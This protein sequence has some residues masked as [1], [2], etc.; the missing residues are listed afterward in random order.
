MNLT[1]YR[2]QG[3][4]TREFL[5]AIEAIYLSSTQPELWPV[6]LQK[7]ADCFGDVG[8]ALLLQRDDGS[9]IP[10]CSTGLA[11]VQQDY[12]ENGWN[13][14]DIRMQR[15]MERMVWQRRE[16]LSDL[17]VLT[18]QEIA[19]DPFYTEFLASHG[20]KYC[21]GTRVAPTPEFAVVMSVQ[22]ASDR[23]PYT[24]LETDVLASLGRHVEQAMRLSIRLLDA[25]ASG[26]AT[27]EALD[28]IGIGVIALDSLKRVLFTNTTAQ[29]MLSDGLTC[30]D[31]HLRGTI[32]EDNEVLQASLD[33]M[34][35]GFPG[36]R[37]AEPKPF[38]L[39]RNGSANPLVVHL[40]PVA[41][42][43]GPVEQFLTRTK[44]LVLLVDPDRSTL[45]DPALLRDV[46]DL[47][48]GEARLASLI[49][50]GL[51]P[52]ESAAKLGITATTA[53]TVLKRIFSKLGISRQNELAAVLNR[54]RFPGPSR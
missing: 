40:L 25:Q 13:F 32:A 33:A 22:R 47:T 34:L 46:F 27:S 50:G 31:D 54:L 18:P 44:V 36:V 41:Q 48:L 53:R 30:V 16:T 29:G 12:V 28:R 51:G 7:I 9:V 23:E 42:S 6:A 2:D 19:T 5:S 38:V 3:Q 10:M 4:S 14:R 11:K 24:A 26:G 37:V 21:V 52:A 20:L 39:R 8:T 45:L 49:C 43:K 1:Q 35:D 17:E 15:S